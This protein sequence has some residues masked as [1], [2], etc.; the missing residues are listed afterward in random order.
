MLPAVPEPWPT[1]RP[2][3]PERVVVRKSTTQL[4]LSGIPG[5]LLEILWLVAA[6]VFY[7][8]STLAELKGFLKQCRQTGA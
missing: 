2:R 6:W 8:V 7:T 1:K 5:S 4:W 3:Y